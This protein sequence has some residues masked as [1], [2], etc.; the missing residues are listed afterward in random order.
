M[1][2]PAETKDLIQYRLNQAGEMLEVG[3]SLAN[4]Q[5]SPRSIINRAYYAM[6]YATLATLAT[7]NKG[8]AKH[9][10][11]ISLFNIHFVKTGIFPK[12]FGRSLHRAFDFRQESDYGADI[13][14]INMD[15]A[16]EILA[17]AEEFVAKVGQYINN[18]LIQ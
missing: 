11:I 14:N 18:I 13:V 4:S 7:I 12:E 1:N 5:I 8:S 9:S 16:C 6:F 2:I 17:D 15:V 10:G 3:H